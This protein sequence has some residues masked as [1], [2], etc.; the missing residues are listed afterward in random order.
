MFDAFIINE[1][2]NKKEIQSKQLD[3]DLSYFELGDTVPN[4]ESDKSSYILVDYEYI[5]NYKD[6]Q[7]YGFIIINNIF[8][9][10]RKL[11]SENDNRIDELFNAYQNNVGLL[12]LKL[13]DILKNKN[14]TIHGLN[15]KISKAQSILYEHHQIKNNKPMLIHHY[16][17]LIEQTL[18][19]VLIK[20]LEFN[21]ILKNGS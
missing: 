20:E 5:N 4:N 2:G 21:W 14:Q 9:D 7:Y 18:E 1:Y 17:E 15:K 8:V 16:A 19:S 6:Y 10:W 12:N 11:S 3:C 13:T